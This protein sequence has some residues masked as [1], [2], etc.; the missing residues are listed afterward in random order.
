MKMQGNALTSRH[1]KLSKL[2]PPP[3]SEFDIA[4][5]AICEQ[6]LA[7]SAA[8]VVFIHA[9]AGFGKTT[10]LRQL[11][12]RFRAAGLQSAWVTVDAADN[13]AGR[14]LNFLAA[15]LEQIGILATTRQADD[16]A[17]LA[18]G[19]LDRIASHEV[20]FALFL[21]EMETLHNPAVLSLISQLIEQLPP[22]ARLVLGSRQVPAI[23]LGRLRAR[24]R[25]LEIEASQLRFS[26][27]E[28]TAFLVAQRKLALA[29]EQVSQLH[30]RTE[31]WAAALWL[32]SLALAQREDSARFI[33]GFSGSHAAIAQYLAEDVLSNQPEAIRLFLL[34]TSALDEFS[35]SLCD[36]VRGRDDSAAILAQLEGANLFLMP[37]DESVGEGRRYRYHS[38]FADFL[39]AQLAAQAPARQ[40]AIRLAAAHWYLAAQRPVQAIGHALA[41]GDFDFAF[42]LLGQHVESLLNRGRFALLVSWLDAVPVGELKRQPRLQLIHAW[43]ITFIRGAPEALKLLEQL[44]TSQ[45][46]P[47]LMAHLLALRP[48]LLG[49]MDRIHDSDEA[50]QQALLH[51]AAGDRFTQG[52]LAI[53]QATIIMMRGRYGEA[54]QYADAARRSQGGSSS[55]INQQ[56]SEWCEGS[57]DLIQGRLQ[58]AI[59]RLKLASSLSSDAVSD[60]RLLV[61]IVLAEALY[62]NDQCGE[63]ERL[64]KVYVPLV[65]EVRMPDP[66]ISAHVVLSRIAGDRGD[67][68][69]AMQLLAELE[70]V[71]HL[72]GLPRV[73]ASARLERAR[74]LLAQGDAQA[75]REELARANDPAVWQMV[76]E[77]SLVANDAE[78]LAIGRL[79]WQLRSGQVADCIAELKAALEAAELAQRH[80]RALKLRVLYAEALQ[81]D[82]QPRLAMRNLSKALRMAAGEGF[83]RSFIDEGPV[84]EGMLRQ[85]LLSQGSEAEDAGGPMPSAHLE[86]LMRAS[87]ST[88]M[89]LPAAAAGV[90]PLT[91]KEQQVIELLA[92]GYSNEAMGEKLFIGETTVRTH[93]RSINL[94]LDARSRSQAVAIARRLGLIR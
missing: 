93:L 35:A 86:R 72:G 51:C 69:Q 90:E 43:A 40:R 36:A 68:E 71:G 46:S 6:V 65:K 9:P 78:T 66:L 10:T 11:R 82:G 88:E 41:S 31:G 23:G 52:I 4:R 75:A 34:E 15:A 25:L 53:S 26:V 76:A 38:L 81:R 12:E 89:T 44:D 87:R 27:A 62:E 37:L 79:R 47:A 54:R 70:Q 18:L 73:V 19:I 28:A 61:G 49:L 56:W 8:R 77:M 84:I 16:A 64:L 91:R 5:S 50:I 63:A 14:F 13:D 92:E 32:A 59:V 57:V 1:G 33:A 30:G 94:K 17:G 24:G 48:L 7:S 42:S 85:F 2:N 21:D 39:K 67:G 60:G 55:I 22:G 20:P 58:Q 45:L 83:V 80:R 74:R 29:P 3:A